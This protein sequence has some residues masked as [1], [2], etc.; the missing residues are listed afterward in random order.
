M[1]R[2]SVWVTSCVV[3]LARVPTARAFASCPPP[4]F[5]TF[6]DATLGKWQY[7]PNLPDQA[8][9]VE[10]VMRSCGGAVQGVR[11]IVLPSEANTDAIGNQQGRYHNRAD[12]GF[13]F[14]DSG[15]YSVGP[16]QI[17]DG[18]NVEFMTSLSFASTLPKRR[19]LVSAPCRVSFVGSNIQ[20]KPIDESNN[21]KIIGLSR[22]PF[23][24]PEDVNM[25]ELPSVAGLQ[26]YAEPRYELRW[27]KETICKMANPS[28]PW[29]LQRAKWES[30]AYEGFTEE[31]GE[32]PTGEK[33]AR[34]DLMGWVRP[35]D[36]GK[37]SEEGLSIQI[38][39]L[40]T[41]TKE[42]WAIV[43]SYNAEGKLNSVILQEGMII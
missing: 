31:H 10:E 11:E 22:V 28:Q 19:M 30:F 17:A 9:E 25:A 8:R 35:F 5:D 6:A 1:V 18:D 13:V 12:D 39:A 21:G 24:Q 36:G 7:G 32:T 16:V 15:S 37:D 34:T 4:R 27:K 38:G 2:V 20:I 42:S 26:T 40:C 3:F 43:R 29:M 23:R 41:A 14:F 33:P